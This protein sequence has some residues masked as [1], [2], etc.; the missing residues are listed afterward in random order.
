MSEVSRREFLLAAAAATALAGSAAHAQSPLK[1]PRPGRSLDVTLVGR[2]DDLGEEVVSF[3][4]P[5]PP[6]FLSD[7]NRVVVLDA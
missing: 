6:G 5:L 3:G 7:A 2:A 4:V 1:I